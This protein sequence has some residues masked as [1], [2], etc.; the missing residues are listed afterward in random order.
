MNDVFYRTM[1]NKIDE[2]IYFVDK[3][4]KITFWNKGA[5]LI[6]GFDSQTVVGSHCYDNILN[7]VDDLGKKLCLGGCPLQKTIEDF[8]ERETQVYLHHKEGHRIKIKVKTLP[9][10]ENNQVIGAVE[11]FNVLSKK[12]HISE[13]E[14]EQ[15][16]ELALH[17][18]LTNLPNR[19]KI[20]SVIKNKI[21]DFRTLDI[22]YG[23]LF[24]DIDFFKK[25]NDDYGHNLGDEMLK[26]VAN[27]LN[28]P[29]RETDIAGRWGG[30]EFIIILGGVNDKALKRIAETTRMLVENS[31]IRY[32]GKDISATV[33]IG[34][35]LAKKNDD[36]QSIIKRADQFMYKSKNTGRNKVTIG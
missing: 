30:E 36:L 20:E 27:T 35:T 31:V 10:Y 16:K 8:K 19:R 32:E 15:L 22:G 14:V 11:I 29:I 13:D 21:E 3:D 4:R 24:I 34:G 9:L 33:S 2:G 17:D 25:F 6:T 26:V 5:E 23:I 18:Q 7:H 28:Q 1:L 12:I